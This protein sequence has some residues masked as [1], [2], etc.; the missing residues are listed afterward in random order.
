LVD[1]CFSN[2]SLD[3]SDLGIMFGDQVKSCCKR[4]VWQV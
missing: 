4:K 2:I 3:Q 1:D